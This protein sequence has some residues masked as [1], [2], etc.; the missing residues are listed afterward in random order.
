MPGSVMGSQTLLSNTNALY[1]RN[2]QKQTIE[3]LIKY[4]IILFTPVIFPI[5][6]TILQPIKWVS[7]Y[8]YRITDLF[9]TT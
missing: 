8:A 7:A 1:S 5:N 4:Q 9:A 2:D 3:T 6:I